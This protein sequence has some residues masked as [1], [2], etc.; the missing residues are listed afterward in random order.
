MLEKLKSVELVE[1]KQDTWR[2]V[3]KYEIK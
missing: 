1:G 2:I 3:E